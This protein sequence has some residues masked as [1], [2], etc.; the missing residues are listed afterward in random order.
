MGGGDFLQLLTQ[1]MV[2]NNNLRGDLDFRDH[3]IAVL[4]ALDHVPLGILAV[5]HRSLLAGFR[6]QAS[7]PDLY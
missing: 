4:R 5:V 3:F 6:D 2:S 7:G 1:Y